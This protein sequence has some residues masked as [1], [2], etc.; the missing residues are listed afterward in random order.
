MEA[1][2]IEPASRD[3]STQASTC[4][5]GYLSVAIRASNRRDAQT[6][7]RERSLVWGVP[8]AAQDDPE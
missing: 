1:A 4:V 2:G 8:D 6:A 7:S 3:V 5:V